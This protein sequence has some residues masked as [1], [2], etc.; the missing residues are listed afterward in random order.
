MLARTSAA[1]PEARAMRQER[2]WL[3]MREYRSDPTLLNVNTCLWLPLRVDSIPPSAE[4]CVVVFAGD[5]PA[6]KTTAA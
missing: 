3:E 2:R 5:Y 6:I 4:I 1:A